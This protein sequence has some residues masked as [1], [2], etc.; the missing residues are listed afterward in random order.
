M[1]QYFLMVSVKKEEICSPVLHI[2]VINHLVF[3]VESSTIL[4]G[5]IEELY[6][7]QI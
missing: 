2:N 5:N 1:K 3:I 7:A 6:L 4:Y